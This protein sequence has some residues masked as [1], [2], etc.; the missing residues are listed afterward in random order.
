MCVRQSHCSNNKAPATRRLHHIHKMKALL[1]DCP[2]Q[3][4]RWTKVT[5]RRLMFISHS[6]GPICPPRPFLRLHGKLHKGAG[7]NT[8]SA[9]NPVEAFVQRYK[10]RETDIKSE[11]ST[12][13]HRDVPV[14]QCGRMPNGKSS[15]IPSHPTALILPHSKLGSRNMTAA[16]RPS[17]PT[18][19]RP[20]AQFRPGLIRKPSRCVNCKRRSISWRARCVG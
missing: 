9:R 7:T 10:S 12:R 1:A 6:D 5:K 11:S 2:P 4:A 8:S 3:F 17:R 20:R 15:R 16:W 19:P 14:V 18:S 13:W